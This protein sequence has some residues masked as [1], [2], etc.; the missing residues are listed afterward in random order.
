MNGDVVRSVI[1]ELVTPGKRLGRHIVHDPRSRNFPAEGAAAIMSV[2]HNATGLPLNQGDIGSCTANAL[3]GALN[4]V[5]DFKGGA[6]RT[7]TDA[8]TLYELET[9]LEG[10]PYPPNDPGGSGLEVCKA[11]VQLGWISSYQHA[12]SLE[13]ALLALVLRPVITGIGW[14]TSFDTPS[15]DGLVVIAMGATVRGGH[16]VVADQ[17]DAPNKLVWFWNSWG[18]TFGV[19][20]RFCMSFDTWQQLLNESG[21][22]T[23]PIP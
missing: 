16:E 13:D 5:P 9:K 8:I 23:V 12:F 17:I 4:S 22:V 11:A 20:G 14:Y 2:V 15:A 3:C 10:D 21:D 7:E 6:P 18:P 19:G 1:P